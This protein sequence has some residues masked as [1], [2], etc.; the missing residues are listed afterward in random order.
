MKGPSTFATILIDTTLDLIRMAYYER[1]VKAAASAEVLLSPPTLQVPKLALCAHVIRAAAATVGARQAG[2]VLFVI[3]V[4][5]AGLRWLPPLR[6]SRP[7]AV[8]QCPAAAAQPGHPGAAPPTPTNRS[9]KSPA[10]AAPPILRQRTRP[11]DRAAFESSST[12]TAKMHFREA[13]RPDALIVRISLQWGTCHEMK[14]ASVGPPVPQLP[15]APL[16]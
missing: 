15:P 9:A 14:P 11:A 12:C 7:P 4:P 6:S 5:V 16:G 13:S 8:P 2:I 3:P 1:P 10:A